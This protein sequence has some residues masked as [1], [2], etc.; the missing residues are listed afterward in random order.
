MGPV[1]RHGITHRAAEQGVDG[2][3]EV[4]RLDV[5]QGVFDGGDLGVDLL[6]GFLERFDEGVD[7]LLAFFEVAGGGLL[8]LGERLLGELQKRG[9]VALEGV[10]GKG[11]EL[12]GQPDLGVA[13]GGK[14]GLELGREGGEPGGFGAQGLHLGSQAEILLLAAAQTLDLTRLPAAQKERRENRGENGG[15]E[16]DQKGG[17]GGM[18]WGWRGQINPG[19]VS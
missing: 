15:E 7:G 12:I 4:L 17:H 10:G 13:L 5:E 2:D 14:L 11:L 9:V 18:V 19:C 3:A 1:D 8:E 16:R 6:E